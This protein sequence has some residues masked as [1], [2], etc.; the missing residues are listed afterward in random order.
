ME[1]TGSSFQ[2]CA[3][4]RDEDEDEGQNSRGMTVFRSQVR[5]YSRRALG[6][7]LRNSLGKKG[8]SGQ[9]GDFATIRVVVALID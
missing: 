9:N 1:R 7:L 6:R 2:F 3:E 4:E 8:T 5:G